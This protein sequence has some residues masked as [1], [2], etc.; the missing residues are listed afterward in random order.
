MP[1]RHLYLQ[2][3]TASQYVGQ[4][5]EH[6]LGRLGIAPTLIALLTH[7][8]EHEPISPSELSRVAGMPTTTLRDNVQRLVDRNLVRRVSNPDDGR[9]YLVR[10]TARGR[11][12]LDAADPALLDAYRALERRLP[13]PREEYERMFAELN[14][15]LE[16]TFGSLVGDVSLH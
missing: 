11:T 6:Q 5:I 14:D 16:A 13:R 9:S 3:A 7:I 12:L 4:I 1:N 10:R 2:T 8:G 15:A